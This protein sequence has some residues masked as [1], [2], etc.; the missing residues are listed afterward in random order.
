MQSPCIAQISPAVIAASQLLSHDSELCNDDFNSVTAH[1]PMHPDDVT[2]EVLDAMKRKID[3]KVICE[4][5]CCCTENPCTGSNAGTN[6]RQG[7]V[8]ATLQTADNILNNQSR[9]KPEISYNMDTNPPSPFMHRDALGQ[10]TT[11]R[12]DR[13][14]T[15][16][17]QEIPGYKG[18]Q[19]RVR[20]PDVIIVKDPSKPPYQDNIDRVVEMKFKGDK[21][22]R[23]QKEA[24]EEIAGENNEL[25]LMEEGGDCT[26]SE[27]GGEK[28]PVP[29]PV[30]IPEEEP[31]VDWWAV[32]E[33]VGMGAVTAVAAV[34]TVALVLV[35]FDGPAGEIAAG[36]GTA[37]AAAR[38]A[39]AFGMIFSATPH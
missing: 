23:E 34:A 3:D 36:A 27:D 6:Q 38:T 14:Q 1:C 13:W 4:V 7:C 26:C 9:Y 24:Y 20:R 15:R 28:E 21:W 39:A 12:S 5:M 11:Q 16:A 31:S 25:K 10:D 18:G 37:A 2:P 32:A 29:Q 35:P 33:T 19:G 8:S 30:A 17:Q 22:G